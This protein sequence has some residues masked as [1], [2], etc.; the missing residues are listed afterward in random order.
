MQIIPEAAN[1]H[2]ITPLQTFTRIRLDEHAEMEQAQTAFSWA[3]NKDT[4]GNS[5]NILYSWQF[6]AL[7]RWVNQARF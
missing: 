1:I 5:L 2:N 7:S 3:S 4:V 6:D